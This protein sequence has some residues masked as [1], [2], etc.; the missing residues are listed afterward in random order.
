MKLWER[1][2]IRGNREV[3]YYDAKNGWEIENFAFRLYGLIKDEMEAENKKGVVF[4]CIGTDRYTILQSCTDQNTR[5]K[6]TA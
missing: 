3:Y 5:D 6:S 2:K 1:I 4:L